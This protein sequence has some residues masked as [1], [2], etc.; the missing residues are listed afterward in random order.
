ML[1]DK[2]LFS[3]VMM[4]G[5]LAEDL[6]AAAIVPVTEVLDDFDADQFAAIY[7]AV[8]TRKDLLDNVSI[9]LVFLLLFFFYPC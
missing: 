8:H 2:L 6:E 9:L 5:T 7:Q 4:V 3:K 1:L